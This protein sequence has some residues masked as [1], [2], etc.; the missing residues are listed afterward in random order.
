MAMTTTTTTISNLD[1]WSIGIPSLYDGR[2]QR[3]LDVFD[4]LSL[5]NDRSWFHSIGSVYLKEIDKGYIER[6][7][8]KTLRKRVRK[9]K[10]KEKLK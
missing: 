9:E 7:E 6:L 4:F 3:F 8:E 10:R 2:L 5:F 1:W